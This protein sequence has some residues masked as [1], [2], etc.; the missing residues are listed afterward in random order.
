MNQKP[1]IPSWPCVFQFDILFSVVLSKSMSISVLEPSLSSSSSLVIL[2][3]HS[4]FLLCFVRFLWHPVVCMFSCRSLPIVDRMFFFVVLE[5]PIL[6]V[7]F[8]LCRYLLNLPSFASTFW[9]ISSSC[10]VIFSC[11]ASSFLFPL[12]SAALFFFHS[13]LFS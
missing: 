8:T 11:V 13:G 12:I 1:Y 9:F 3:I 4:A 7:L 5:S 6:S 2:L 10:T